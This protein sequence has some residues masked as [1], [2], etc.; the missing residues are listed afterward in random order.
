MF[1]QVQIPLKLLHLCRCLQAQD[2]ASK[3]LLIW[4]QKGLVSI[5]EQAVLEF[6]PPSTGASRI[7]LTG[8]KQEHQ[9]SWK[10]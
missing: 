1:Q 8:S 10:L 5:A 6:S 7:P 9:Q 2:L 3:K 4:L